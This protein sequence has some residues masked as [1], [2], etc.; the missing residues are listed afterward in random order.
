MRMGCQF[1]AKVIPLSYRMMFVS[2]IKQAL[3]NASEE[4]FEQL[5]CYDGKSNKKAKDFC[6]SVFFKNYEIKDDC[7]NLKEGLSF[8][9]SSPDKLFIGHLFN[10]LL[11]IKDF[12]YKDYKIK[13]GEIH[14]IKE[15]NISEEKVKFKTLSPIYIADRAEKPL[16]PNDESFVSEFNYIADMILTNYRGNGLTRSIEFTPLNMKKTVAKEEISQFQKNTGKK[17]MYLECY[18]GTFMLEGAISDLKDIYAL[19]VSLRR[20]QGFGMIEVV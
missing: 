3:R 17:Y 19:G 10:G 6:F 2:L 5:Y 8:N 7:V 9:I 11:D 12:T 13:R 20:N 4:Y 18:T 15:K 14:L 16:S 1:E